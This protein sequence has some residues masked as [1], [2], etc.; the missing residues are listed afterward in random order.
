MFGKLVKHEFRATARIIP[1]VYLVTI[2]LALVHIIT[3]RFNL[4]AISKI[5]LVLMVIMCFAQVAITFV[6]LIWR[7]YKNLYSNEGYLTHTLP[8]HPSLLLWSK[9]IVS[10]VWTLLSYLVGAAV[11]AAVF[12][13][14]IV[15]SSDKFGALSKAYNEIL[16]VT[17]MVNLQ[18]AL[19]TAVA[20]FVVV[21]IVL[22]YAEMYFAITVGSL[23]KLHSLGI[24]GPILIY[25]AEYVVL[26]IIN[27]IVTLFVP[28]G[29]RITT[30]ADGTMSTIQIVFQNMFSK[31]GSIFSNA[32]ASS[33]AGSDMIVGI[34]QYI[35]LPFIAVGLLL[36][37]ARIISRHT[38]VK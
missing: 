3:N 22:L 9:L 31:F 7:Y 25:F 27:T 21:S 16:A 1:F 11:V 8:V 23:S 4:G 33:A 29:I 19:W 38:S 36:L 35:L 13:S 34:G 18:P 37:T 6:L 17:G 32:N 30:G 12:L 14:D 20:F 10:F 28:L 15:E 5:S 24:G 2:F 26:Q